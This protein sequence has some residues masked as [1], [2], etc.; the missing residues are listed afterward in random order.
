MLLLKGRPLLEYLLTHLKQQRFDQVAINLHFKPEMIRE[1]FGAGGNGWPALTYSFEAD[2][3]GTAGGLKNFDSFFKSEEL[4]L[5]QYGDVFTDQD[6]SAMV[7]FHRERGALATVL[8]HQR[9]RSNSVLTL[10]EQNRIVG[11]LER[12]SEQARQGISSPWVNSGVCI[13]SPEIL[14]D[15]PSGQSCDLPRDVFA[16]L[17]GT[18]RL[19]AFPLS[20]YRCAIDSPERL[21]EARSALAERRCRLQLPEKG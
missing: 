6:F 1:Y 16:R 8:V 13:C 14:N 18:G 7:Q 21:A 9:A 3:L 19:Y 2:L 4:F 10:D 12:P 15:I 11:F 5:V 17:T 20:G